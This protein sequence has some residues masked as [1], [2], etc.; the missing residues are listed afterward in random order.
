MAYGICLISLVCVAQ[1]P[2]I[3]FD[4]KHHDFGK[5]LPGKTVSHK[6]NITNVGDALLRIKEI[7]ESCS[8]T[9][10]MIPKWKLSPGES[11][12]IDVRFN[13]SGMLGNIQKSITLISDD[14]LNPKAI[15]R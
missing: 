9:K 13:S 6:F 7:R 5:M 12:S 8:C 10:A 2:I 4:K 14:P 3:S 15:L 11:T 1:T